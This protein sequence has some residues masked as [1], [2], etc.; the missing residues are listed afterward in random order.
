MLFEKADVEEFFKISN[1]NLDDSI[2]MEVRWIEEVEKQ[3][4]VS[5]C[6][7][8][9]ERKSIRAAKKLR[10]DHILSPMRRRIKTALPL[11]DSR[12]KLIFGFSYNAGYGRLSTAIHYRADRSDYLLGDGDEREMIGGVGLIAMSVLVRC[13]RLMGWPEAP[14][15]AKL[16][17]VSGKAVP[18]TLFETMVELDVEV[19]DFVLARG[20]LAEIIEVLVSEFG[21]KSYRV[22]YLAERPMPHILEDFFPSMHLKILYRRSQLI[23]RMR[24]IPKKY[25]GPTDFS[26]KIDGLSWEDTQLILRESVT[27][28]WKAGL[29]RRVRH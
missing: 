13:Y 16:E 12:E 14:I 18:K 29:G 28:G 20:D 7:Y 9:F 17:D 21:Y 8:L 15:V 3:L 4:D 27:E 10:G 22:R 2:A 23:E 25:G 26:E 5:K 11:M 6:W 24:Q 1:A 19:G